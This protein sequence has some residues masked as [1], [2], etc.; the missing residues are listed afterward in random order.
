MY[1]NIDLKDA[2]LEELLKLYNRQSLHEVFVLLFGI[3][4]ALML[5]LGSD[6]CYNF[7]WIDERCVLV[8]VTQATTFSTNDLREFCNIPEVGLQG[9]TILQCKFILILG[10]LGCNR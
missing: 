3:L 4:C 1:H 7:A 5:C 8:Q 9:K 6:L 10:V 2:E